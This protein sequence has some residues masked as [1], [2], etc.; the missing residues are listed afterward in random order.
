M[1]L[2][3]NLQQCSLAIRVADRATYHLRR[4]DKRSDEKAEACAKVET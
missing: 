2:E 3:A 1:F 4:Y